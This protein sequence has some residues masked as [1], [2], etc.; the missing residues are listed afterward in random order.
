M[1]EDDIA[2]TVT[3]LKGKVVEFG[4]VPIQVEGGMRISSFKDPNCVLF[5]LEDPEE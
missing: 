2:A 1:F 3:E 4:L 5:E